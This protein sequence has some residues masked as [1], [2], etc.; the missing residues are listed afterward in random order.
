MKAMGIDPGAKGG[1][2]LLNSETNEQYA[3]AMPMIAGELDYRGVANT[4]LSHAPDIIIIEKVHAMPQQG[5]VSMFNFGKN[6]GALLA[7]ISTLGSAYLTVT[8]QTWKKVVLAGTAK[9]KDAAIQ[10]CYQRYPQLNLVLP[11]CRT[12]HDGIADAICL[13]HYGLHYAK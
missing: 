12:S 11:R 9:D 3:I 8:P 1:I 13:A 2:A 10:F 7:L 5:V 6:Y 4:I